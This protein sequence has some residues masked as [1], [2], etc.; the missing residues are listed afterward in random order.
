MKELTWFG[1]K[2]LS[3][4]MMKVELVCDERVELI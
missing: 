1:M 4:F 2:G 3:S